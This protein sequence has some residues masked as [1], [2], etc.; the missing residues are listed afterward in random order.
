MRE[1]NNGTASCKGDMEKFVFFCVPLST[2]EHS[3]SSSSFCSGEPGSP[4][5]YTLLEAQWERADGFFGVWKTDLLSVTTVIVG[6]TRIIWWDLAS[7][8]GL[9]EVSISELS[10]N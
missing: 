1:S 3:T 5:L 10:F 7:V 4:P 8:S 9:F 2:A 6:M